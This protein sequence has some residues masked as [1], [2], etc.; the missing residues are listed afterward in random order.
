MKTCEDF[1]NE[2]GLIPDCCEDCHELAEEYDCLYILDDEGEE[3]KLCCALVEWLLAFCIPLATRI[4][5]TANKI[6]IG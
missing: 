6:K 2:Y 3:Y 1:R 4:E 5:I